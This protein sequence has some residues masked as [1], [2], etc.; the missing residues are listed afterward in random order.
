VI[1]ALGT[2]AQLL[3]SEDEIVQSFLKQGGLDI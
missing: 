2:P 3:E 1:T